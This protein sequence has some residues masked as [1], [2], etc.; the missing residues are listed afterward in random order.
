MDEAVGSRDTWCGVGVWSCPIS[1]LV[2]V[3]AFERNANVTARPSA[4]LD[5]I[6][7][8]CMEGENERNYT[9][10]RVVERNE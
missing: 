4:P 2:T 9:V 10:E 1:T 6:T 5:P 3:Q 8:A 7:R